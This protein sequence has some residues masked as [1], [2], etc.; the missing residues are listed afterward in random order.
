MDQLFTPD[1]VV[2]S[3][4]GAL[5]QAVPQLPRDSHRV[6]W[7]EPSVG[8]GAFWRH[9]PSGARVGF[10]IDPAVK[11]KYHAKDDEVMVAD[12]LAASTKLPP[13][14]APRVAI[15]NPPFSA[16]AAAGARPR[17][18]S[19]GMDNMALRFLARCAD[20][21][22]DVVAFV[23]PAS[24]GK[25]TMQRR[26]DGR[27]R[28]LHTVT[29][30]T[31]N[32]HLPGRRRIRAVRCVIQIWRRQAR[33]RQV[34]DDQPGRGAPTRQRAWNAAFARGEVPFLLLRLDD[35]SANV[36]LTNWGK[37]GQ[38]EADPQRVAARV[39]NPCPS[40]RGRAGDGTRY[41]LHVPHQH[42][43]DTLSLLRS[44]AVQAALRA[45][46]A[47][48]PRRGGSSVSITFF[49]TLIWRLARRLHPPQPNNHGRVRGRGASGG[50]RGQD[51]AAGGPR[52]AIGAM[53]QDFPGWK[54]DLL[55]RGSEGS[56]DM[57]SST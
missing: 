34:E 37:V 7:L 14:R 53:T 8:D 41:H 46:A 35:L 40:S 44:T 6:E 3:V 50:T 25:R 33:R 29:L 23:L 27:W 24:F 1:A 56:D 4:F 22:C 31:I 11:A 21:A 18:S 28:L 32:F 57:L 26:V 12:F 17:G 30:G 45:E 48:S 54:S 10:D 20:V 43:D 38:I 49:L 36:L 52:P 55:T 15:G 2:D 47:R 16:T 5:R 42:W 9:L 13:P 19:G 39:L 51:E